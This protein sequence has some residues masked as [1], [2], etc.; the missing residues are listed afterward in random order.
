MSLYVLKFGGSSVGTISRIRHVASIVEKFIERGDR[1]VIVTSAMQGVTNHLIDL[2][3]SF[4][5]TIYS[6]TKRIDGGRVRPLSRPPAS[7]FMGDNIMH[8][9]YDAV[10]STGEQMAAGLLALCLCSMDIPAISLNCWQIPIRSDGNFSNANITEINAE[11]ILDFVTR[12]IVPVITGFQGVS[13]DGDVMTI[14]RGGSDATACIVSHATGAEECLIY[15]DVDGVYT[16]DPRTVLNTKWL[17]EISYDEML[18]LSHGGARVMQAKSVLIARRYKLRVRILS[19]FIESEG[20]VM[21]GKTTYAHQDHRI[22]GIAHNTTI[23]RIT[24]HNYNATKWKGILEQIDQIRLIQIDGDEL[25]ALIPKTSV[26]AIK[27][28]L[29]G[30]Y[31]IDE[32]AGLITIAGQG[33]KADPSVLIRI[34]EIAGDHGI[35]IKNIVVGESEISIVVPLQNTEE[36]VNYL[37]AGFIE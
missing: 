8:R 34:T 11:N 10:I 31:V 7:E 12:G 28:T 2:T 33:F 27:E 22:A 14:G 35:Q 23:A 24:I 26:P 16:A 37:H 1:V 5:E 36:V 32:N 20:T 3:K 30:G 9:E 25:H 17:R 15:T 18:A 13:S 19:S 6:V 29:C 21:T 4:T